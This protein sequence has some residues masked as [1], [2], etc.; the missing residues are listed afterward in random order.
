MLED[1]KTR[2]CDN[3]GISQSGGNSHPKG[4]REK[5][6]LLVTSFRTQLSWRQ[7]H[8]GDSLKSSRQTDRQIDTN[9]QTLVS[10]FLLLSLLSLSIMN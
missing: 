6:K 1:L 5:L 2:W 9:T 4:L 10:P 7:D 3:Q 8:R